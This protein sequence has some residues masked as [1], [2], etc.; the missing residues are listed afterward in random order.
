MSFLSN[1]RDTIYET[2]SSQTNRQSVNRGSEV[3]S[4][5]KDCEE[6]GGLAS[7]LM[8]RNGRYLKDVICLEIEELNR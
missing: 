8:V 2:Q 4:V 3:A 7:S 6:F 1:E 5:H